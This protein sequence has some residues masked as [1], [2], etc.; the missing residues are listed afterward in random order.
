MDS[1]IPI[2]PEGYKIPDYDCTMRDWALEDQGREIVN[3][4]AAEPWSYLKDEHRAEYVRRNYYG[5]VCL[6]CGLSITGGYRLMG[7]GYS[8]CGS[9]PKDSPC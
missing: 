2:I 8:C 5:P 1:T 9:P 4:C 6:C 3:P 7:C